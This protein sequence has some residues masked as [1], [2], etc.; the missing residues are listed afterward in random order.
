MRGAWV[1]IWLAE[2]WEPAIA[3]SPPV[4]GA[5]VEILLYGP[6]TRN[7]KGSPPVRGAWVEI[8]TLAGLLPDPTAVAPRAGGVG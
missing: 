1:E 4:R 6:T 3:Q 5:W 2:P 7:G 8:G